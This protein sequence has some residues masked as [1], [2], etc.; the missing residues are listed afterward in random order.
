MI[1]GI[2]SKKRSMAVLG[3]DND[4]ISFKAIMARAS[5]LLN[6]LLTRALPLKRRNDKPD[7]NSLNFAVLFPD[8]IYFQTVYFVSRLW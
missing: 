1:Y 2:A 3:C 8:R 5:V 6:Y 7:L 4:L